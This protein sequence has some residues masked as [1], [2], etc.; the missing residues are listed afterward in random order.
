M[1]KQVFKAEKLVGFPV[2]LF[3]LL[4]IPNL[5]KTCRRIVSGEAAKQAAYRFFFEELYFSQKRERAFALSSL[6][7]KITPIL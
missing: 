3:C 4:P 7:I 1:G 6:N 5:K 2:K